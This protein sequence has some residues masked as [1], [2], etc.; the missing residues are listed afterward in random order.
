MNVYGF[1][2]HEGRFGALWYETGEEISVYLPHKSFG[3]IFKS[4]L[5]IWHKHHDYVGTPSDLDEYSA[6]INAGAL[7]A[8]QNSTHINKKTIKKMDIPPGAYFPRVWRGVPPKNILGGGYNGMSLS[9]AD[10]RICIESAQAAASLFE[11]LIDLFRVVEPSEKNSTTYG[12]RIRELLI[13]ACAEVESCW[14]GVLSSNSSSPKRIY[15]TQDYVKLLPLL[16]L[17]E[18]SVKLKNYPGYPVIYPFLG[19]DASQGQTTK[20]LSWYAS[21]NAVKH[22]REGEFEKATL[23]SLIMA[24][25]ALHVMQVAQWGPELYLRFI[26]NRFSVFDTKSIPEYGPENQYICVEGGCFPIEQKHYFG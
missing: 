10:Q 13:L 9:D 6:E 7:V 18:W 5:E 19:W 20:S 3:S 12:H 16:K 1:F 4:S 2:D 26:G 17:D 8:A 23:Q 22:D 15:T 24:L 14:R 25:G 11:E 21:Y